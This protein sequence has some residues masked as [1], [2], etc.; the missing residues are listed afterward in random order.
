M[1]ASFINSTILILFFI[2][3]NPTTHLTMR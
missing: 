2:S 1:I 3:A